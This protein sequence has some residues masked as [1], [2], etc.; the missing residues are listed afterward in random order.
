MLNSGVEPYDAASTAHVT[1][2]VSRSYDSPVV[3]EGQ[4]A[5]SSLLSLLQL[6]IKCGPR[7]KVDHYASKQ[8]RK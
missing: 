7:V 4:I 8:A 2:P 3:Q 6:Y 5:N 1:Y